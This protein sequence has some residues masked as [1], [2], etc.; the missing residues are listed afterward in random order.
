[1]KQKED[2]YSSLDIDI[3]GCPCTIAYGG[4]H[5]AT[6]NLFIDTNDKSV[7]LN[8]DVASY[9]PS[10]I[11]QNK[12]IS[13]NI[14][15]GSSY[16]DVYSKRLYAKSIQDTKTSEALK[17]VLNTTYGASN[18]KYNE[19]YD[20][21]MAH[22][23][24][25]SGQLYLI[26]LAVS[27]GQQLKEVTICQVN[28]DGIMIYIP[29]W[30][31]E[32]AQSIIDEWCERTHFGMEKDVISKLRQ[33]DVN[34]YCIEKSD[35]K[36]KAKGAML[37]TWKGDSFVSNS[38]SICSKA[39]VENLLHDVPVEK[40]INE[41]TDIFA[42]QMIT[43]AGGT[44]EKVVHVFD[45]DKERTIQRVNRLYATDNELLGTVYKIKANGRRDKLASAP[46]HCIV[47][48]NCELSIDKINKKWYIDLCNK[49]INKFKGIKIPKK[50][51]AK[52]AKEKKMEKEEIEDTTPDL[53]DTDGLEMKPQPK[54]ASKAVTTATITVVPKEEVIVKRKKRTTKTPVEPVIAKEE[55]VPVSM[56]TKTVPDC[57]QPKRI[58]TFKEKLYQ[59]AIDMTNESKNFI[60][61]GY[62]DHQNYS[63]TSA[64]Q[65]KTLLNTCLTKNRL[66]GKLD[67]LMSTIGS[68]FKSDKMTLILYQ[69]VY[70]IDDVDS[71]GKKTY[72][73]WSEGADNGDKGI[74]KAK[75]LALKDMI[76]A[77]FLISDKD[78]D[79]DTSTPAPSKPS[80]KPKFV[81]PA[82]KIEIAHDVAKEV[83]EATDENK[84]EIKRRIEMIR[85]AKKSPK[86][87]QSTL[88]KLD[89][90]S[91]TEMVVKLTKL[92][93][94]GS[95]YDLV[96][97]KE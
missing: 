58:L 25:I 36:I 75:T 54:Q 67:D 17:R 96:F 88:D 4:I 7:I 3:Y 13:R 51:R 84:N 30:E 23:V 11:I 57:N 2:D 10:L 68:E 92:E 66:L 15:D 55:I 29:T 91:N 44:Y 76:K 53:F 60:S 37:S 56:E 35:G 86:Y 79:I 22:S 18:N 39:I 59:L 71:E 87:G 74:S 28:T 40:T 47:D 93:M 70:T 16:A 61:D 46:L 89:T 62:N 41:C 12:Y 45:T 27:F 69:G 14:K 42:F 5:G 9:Y 64:M 19:L 38:M 72:L 82:K 20:P 50:T 52:K 26:E 21:L 34:N 90:L 1:M 49:R 8:Y 97:D 65:Y 6:K 77:N 81:S 78:D 32:Q 33:K 85:E 43:K 48:N 83:P 24:C 94:T 63:Y 95:E 73:V 31:Q 80:N